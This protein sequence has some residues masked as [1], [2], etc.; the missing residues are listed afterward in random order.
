VGSASYVTILFK[1][2]WLEF[3]L[4]AVEKINIVSSK[5]LLT[6]KTYDVDSFVAHSVPT[7]SLV[8]QYFF[9]SMLSYCEKYWQF[10]LISGLFLSEKRGHIWKYFV[11]VLVLIMACL[12][13]GGRGKKMDTG[14]RG[15]G[16]D[17]RL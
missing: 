10:T 9:L 6:R 8:L 11:T 16:L 4:N 15:M 12:S 7:G 17:R 14:E 2:N 1:I 3:L 13:R 5:K